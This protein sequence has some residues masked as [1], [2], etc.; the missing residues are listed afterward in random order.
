M[1]SDILEQNVNGPLKSLAV[2]NH[3]HFD[4]LIWKLSE[5]KLVMPKPDSIF[6]IYREV[7]STRVQSCLVIHV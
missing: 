2:I 4:N 7:R 5:E 1:L 3:V 6:I